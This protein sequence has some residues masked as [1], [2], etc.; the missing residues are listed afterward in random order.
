MMVKEYT[1]KELTA[2]E[3]TNWVVSP[4]QASG[5]TTRKELTKKAAVIKTRYDTFPEGTHYG[6]A[7]EIILPEDYRACVTQLDTAW[8]F[9][10]PD[11]SETY[12][13]AIKSK[14]A[15]T[16]AKMEAT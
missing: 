13:P 11:L 5:N 3:I 15:V 12:D 8:I 4:M 10:V 1:I 14:T 7:A 16:I 9:F 2:A 6:Y